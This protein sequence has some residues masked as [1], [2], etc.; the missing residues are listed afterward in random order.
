M[1]LSTLAYPSVC[2]CVVCGFSPFA[3]IINLSLGADVGT[4]GNHSDNGDAAT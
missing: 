2:L 4:S 3:M 1:N